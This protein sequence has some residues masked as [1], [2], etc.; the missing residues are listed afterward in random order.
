MRRNVRFAVKQDKEKGFFMDEKIRLQDELSISDILFVLWKKVKLLLVVFLVGIIAGACF[1][2]S[3]TSGKNYYGTGMEFYVNPYKKSS[4]TNGAQAGNSQYGVYG[5]Y[6]N[7]VMDNMIKLLSSDV[8]AEMLCLDEDGLPRSEWGK[9]GK[10][11]DGKD[12]DELVKTAK[13]QV[14]EKDEAVATAK[15][16]IA[17]QEDI[18]FKANLAITEAKEVKTNSLDKTEIEEA[19]DTIKTEKEK[20]KA[21]EEKIFEQNK[22]LQEVKAIVT[23]VVQAW[24]K[25]AHYRRSINSVKGAV[26]YSYTNDAANTTETLAKSF[27]YVNVSVLNNEDLANYLFDELRVELTSYVSNNMAVPSGYDGTNCQFIST[28]SNVKYLNPNETQTTA[29]KYAILLGLVALVLACVAV[30]IIDRS[31]KR[32]RN[33]EYT[34]ERFKIPVLGVIPSMDCDKK[35]G[36]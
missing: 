31:D 8:F 17:V 35:K 23:P 22:V 19:L 27:I 20:I 18:I 6:G 4:N 28:A 10:N 7:A 16:I 32:L 21:A 36:V 30:I 3:Q 13:T 34:M 33:Y 25:T 5:A 1:G 9:I 15:K 29:I 24:Q 2:V 26:S 12:V 11:T 14:R